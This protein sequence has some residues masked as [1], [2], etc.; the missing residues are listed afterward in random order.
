MLKSL[1]FRRNNALRAVLSEENHPL[2]VASNFTSLHH[3]MVDC[4]PLTAFIVAE[5]VVLCQFL[6]NQCQ[7]FDTCCSASSLSLWPSYTS[8]IMIKY[9]NIIQKRAKPEVRMRRFHFLESRLRTRSVCICYPQTRT[10]S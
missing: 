9:I 5:V 3:L 1:W 8:C 2:W 4:F 10:C 6:H 7:F